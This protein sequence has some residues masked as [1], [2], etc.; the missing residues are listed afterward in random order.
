MI[1]VAKTPPGFEPCWV[2]GDA[3]PW[4]TGQRFAIPVTSEHPQ[5]AK[6]YLCEFH[7]NYVFED[8]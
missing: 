5:G 3:V 1:T 8:R 4:Q 7:A 6:G 2:C